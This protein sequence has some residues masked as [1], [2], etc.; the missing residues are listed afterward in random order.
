VYPQIQM[1]R[2]YG[3]QRSGGDCRV[4]TE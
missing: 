1:S 4:W 3:S 2:A